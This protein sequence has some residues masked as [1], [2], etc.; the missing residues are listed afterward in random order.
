MSAFLE[1]HAG[2][3]AALVDILVQSGDA[4]LAFEY[5]ERAR[6][7]ALAD[8]LAGRAEVPLEQLLQAERPSPTPPTGIA[9]A[10]DLIQAMLPSTGNP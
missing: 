4:E 2:L 5:C 6:S 10:A 8:L 1:S 9:E 3:Y 7:R